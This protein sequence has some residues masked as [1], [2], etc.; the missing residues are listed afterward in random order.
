MNKLTKRDAAK[1]MAV[2][3]VLD[4]NTFHKSD[5]L[6][7]DLLEINVMYNGDK[8]YEQLFSKYCKELSECGR[9][10]KPLWARQIMAERYSLNV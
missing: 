3:Y 1:V 9:G 7:H 10:E 2:K 6:K 5:R 4:Y 8:E